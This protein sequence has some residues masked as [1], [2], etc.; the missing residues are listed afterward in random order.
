MATSAIALA[1]T[2][3]GLETNDE[4]EAYGESSSSLTQSGSGWQL[5]PGIIKEVATNGAIVWAIG[6]DAFAGSHTIHRYT[7]YGWVKDTT[8]A[9]EKIAVDSTG[10]PWVVTSRGDVYRRVYENSGPPSFIGSFVWKLVP[11]VCATDIAIGG[12]N[13]ST[14]V[15][16]C[17]NVYGGHE[18]YNLDR[19]TFTW[20][21]DVEAAG[22][23]IAVDAYGTPWLVNSFGDIFNRNLFVLE[24]GK[25]HWQGHAGKASDIGT[26]GRDVW[27]IGITPNPYGFDVYAKTPEDDLF[28]RIGGG[29]TKISSGGYTPWVI[30]NQG[31]PFRRTN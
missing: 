12:N 23:A 17:G 25:S 11:G 9:G 10:A 16:G 1:L 30:D 21:R 4:Y 26:W 29:A 27:V 14:W 7:D 22:T 5:M 18:I 6:T 24:P 19:N 31:H 2:G 13:D 20:K 3:C 28:T 15:V 8:G